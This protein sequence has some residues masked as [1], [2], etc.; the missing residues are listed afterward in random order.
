MWGMRART[1]AWSDPGT[2]TEP[3]QWA[4]R[5]VKTG[6]IAGQRATA[7]ATMNAAANAMIMATTSR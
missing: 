7:T 6:C 2:G 3:T 5:A 1:V 4:V